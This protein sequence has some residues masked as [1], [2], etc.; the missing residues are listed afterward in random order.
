MGGY[1]DNVAAATLFAGAYKKASPK[2][3]L[4]VWYEDA[5][6]KEI[7]ENVWFHFVYHFQIMPECEWVL[8]WGC[9]KVLIMQRSAVQ[10][11]VQRI[12]P[13]GKLN[14]FGDG[15]TIVGY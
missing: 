9:R 5:F 10:G 1:R 13:L 6:V 8:L 12:G 11:C 3:T 4:K 7:P 15:L 14:G 2:K